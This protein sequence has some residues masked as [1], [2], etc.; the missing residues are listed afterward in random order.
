MSSTYSHGNYS[1]PQS[2]ESSIDSHKVYI[3]SFH[4][5]IVVHANTLLDILFSSLVNDLQNFSH[6]SNR[7]AMGRQSQASSAYGGARHNDSE[8]VAQ[9]PQTL[10]GVQQGSERVMTTHETHTP[11]RTVHNEGVSVQI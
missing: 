10:S 4:Q 1:S 8:M 2:N 6:T 5:S 7:P 3:L 9:Q 11:S